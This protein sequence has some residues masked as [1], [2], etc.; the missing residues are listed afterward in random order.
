MRVLRCVAYAQVPNELR[1]TLDS[2]GEKCIFVGYSDES[3]AYKMY[4]PSTKKVIINRDV[5]F[6]EEEAWDGSLEKKINVKA[7][8]P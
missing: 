3:K 5:N 1:D 7:C 2:K 6:I 4:N 8:I